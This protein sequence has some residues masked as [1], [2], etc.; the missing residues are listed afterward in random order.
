NDL[1]TLQRNQWD[2]LVNNFIN[3]PHLVTRESVLSMATQ[4]ALQNPYKFKDS[5]GNIIIVG[6]KAPTGEKIDG[7]IRARSEIFRG[8]LRPYIT[9]ANQELHDVL[10]SNINLTLIL[11]G[12]ING[13]VPDFNKLIDILTRLG[14]QKELGNNSILYID[15]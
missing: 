14:A 4:D 11:Q 13:F 8:A 15:E 1:T 12:S 9:T 3:I 5:F 7:R 2:N 6:P 10:E